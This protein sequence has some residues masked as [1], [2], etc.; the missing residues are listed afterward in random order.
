MDFDQKISQFI[1]DAPLYKKLKTI[2]PIKS[3]YDL[4]DFGVK[5]F[6][7][8]EKSE[9]THKLEIYPK[10]AKDFFG[11]LPATELANAYAKGNAKPDS[12]SFVQHYRG[13]CQSCKS[14][15]FE[16]LIEVKN[17]N[18]LNDNEPIYIIRKLGQSPAY[19]IKPDKIFLDYLT[20]EDIE[21][22]KKAL[23]NLSHSFGIGAYAYLRRIVE[24]EILRL[25]TDISELNTEHSRDLK[26]L[27]KKNE[28]EHNMS[29][30][31]DET[32]KY[33]P[34]S[35]KNIGDNPFKL[36]YGELSVGIHK[37]KDDNCLDRAEYLNKILKFVIK[38]ICEEKTEIH[39]V[40]NAV[41]KLRENPE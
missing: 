35:L 36:L 14:H 16:V 5:V 37:L 33:I 38:R 4:N 22:Y 21:N 20:E 25:L 1:G 29:A 27:L 41:L 40:K 17:N 6:C 19:E 31:I 12:V 8:N 34:E 7:S 9:Q 10:A 23:M 18:P 32:F 3:P 30:L 24:N 13:I 2:I 15:F 11:G 26:Q 28:M 39:D